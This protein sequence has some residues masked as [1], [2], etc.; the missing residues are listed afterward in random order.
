MQKDIKSIKNTIREQRLFSFFYFIFFLF[1]FCLWRPQAVLGAFLK[2]LAIGGANHL[3]ILTVFCSMLP[4]Q[5]SLHQNILNPRYGHYV[6]NF[7]PLDDGRKILRAWWGSNLGTHALPI[8]LRIT[9]TPLSGSHV[10]FVVV[11]GG[12]G[13]YR[14]GCSYD[15]SHTEG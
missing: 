13:H 15:N 4:Y 1:T 2:G 8:L 10:F 6:G 3:F 14:K 9:L 11:V 5:C 12:A 7:A